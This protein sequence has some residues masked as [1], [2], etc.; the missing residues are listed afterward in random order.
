MAVTPFMTMLLSRLS[1]D[2][3]SLRH[4]DERLRASIP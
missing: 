3:G 1:G 4:A 2:I